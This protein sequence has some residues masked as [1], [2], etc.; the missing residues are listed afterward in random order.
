MVRIKAFTMTRQA[1][2][3]GDLYG[4]PLLRRV[5]TDGGLLSLL[6]TLPTRTP[7]TQG[8]G[9]NSALLPLLA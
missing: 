3:Y 1:L 4:T 2:M 5:K 8:I 9:R 7:L 6:K